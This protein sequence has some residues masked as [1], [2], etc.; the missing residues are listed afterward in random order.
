MRNI[1]IAT[2]IVLLMVGCSSKSTI[3]K[4]SHGT[5][6]ILVVDDNDIDSLGDMQIQALDEAHN[7]CAKSGKKYVFVTQ[8]IQEARTAI[9]PREVDLYFKCE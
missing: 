9:Q 6:E 8:R 7:F 4:Y 3:K 5:Y 2:A 1:I